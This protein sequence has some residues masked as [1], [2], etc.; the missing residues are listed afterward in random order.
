[1]NE[2]RAGE[3][4][5]RS[6]ECGVVALFKPTVSGIPNP[7]IH[8]GSGITPGDDRC[9]GGSFDDDV[10]VKTA[11]GQ[12]NGLETS[13]GS[14]GEQEGKDDRKQGAGDVRS[15]EHG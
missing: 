14:G 12:D 3:R 8:R 1:M 2:R 5:A 10:A 15:G 9:R 6:W 7:I 11:A 4:Q 13:T